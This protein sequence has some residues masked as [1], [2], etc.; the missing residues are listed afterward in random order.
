MNRRAS[1]RIKTD[2]RGEFEGL[3]AD[4]GRHLELDSDVDHTRRL[5]TDHVPTMVVGRA[6]LLL[7]T[8]L[9]YLMEDA[10]EAL[11]G[12]PTAVKND[13][14][15][16]ELRTRVKDSFSLEP[17]TLQFS[18]DPRVIAGG[19]AAGGTASAGG[20][21]MAL[22]LNGALSRIVAGLVTLVASTLAFRM[23]HG[24]ATG[25]ARQR[26]NDDVHDY[27]ERSERHVSSWLASVGQYFMSEF[28]AFR[29][30]GTRSTGANS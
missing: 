9:S 15:D 8:L 24:A 6:K 17:E 3:R 16:L 12:A 28:E 7:D 19:V 21:V 1:A 18:F 30:A 2:V 22:L 26:L 4:L 14:Y 23:A 5:L 29:H 25:T 11:A 20:M 27:V 13:F 10:T